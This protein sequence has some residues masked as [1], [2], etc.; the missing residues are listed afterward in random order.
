M[1]L[2]V[3]DSTKVVSLSR[4]YVALCIKSNYQGYYFRKFTLL[5]SVE[6]N[7]AEYASWYFLNRLNFEAYIADVLPYEDYLNIKDQV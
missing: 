1:S 2:L 4:T 3:N 5:D 6:K 7:N